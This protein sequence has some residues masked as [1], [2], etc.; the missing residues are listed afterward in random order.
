MKYFIVVGES[1]G[2]QHGA[3][4][5][6]AIQ[7]IDDAA[8]FRG[9]GG[10]KLLKAGVTLDVD[11]AQYNVMGFWEVLKNY[12]RFTKLFTLVSNII[13]ETKPDRVILIDY[14]GFNM[15]I[16]QFCKAHNIEVHFYILPKIWAWNEGRITKLKSAIDAGYAIL[17]FEED[18]FKSKGL[19]VTYVGNPV[20]EQM[21]R[22]T[23]S[24]HVERR[25]FIALLPGSR[26]Q[27]IQRSLPIMLAYASSQAAQEFVVIAA[28]NTVYDMDLPPN[29]RVDYRPIHEAIVG[30]SEAIVM[31][32]TASLETALLNVPQV[33]C[34]KANWISY[35]LGKRLIKV[36]YISLV[37]L[38]LDKL[39]IKELIQDNFNTLNLD[40]AVKELSKASVRKEMMDDYRRLRDALS[41]KIASKTAAQ[42]IVKGTNE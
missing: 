36:S 26:A 22:V 24:L 9:M 33:V 21:D 40:V 5:V 1:S 39:V 41:N 38:I 20:A 19:E 13:L 10:P 18:Y 7:S 27:E 42:L 17:P 32:G 14:G 3:D 28:T 6:R 35:W 23:T 34:Y 15:R 2:D 4:L 8:Q 37:N 30:A 16:G 12:R 31:S 11:Y 25:P 29:V